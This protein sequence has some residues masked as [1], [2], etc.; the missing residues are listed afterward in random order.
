MKIL[1]SKWKTNI[2]NK[3]LLAISQTGMLKGIIALGLVFLSSS[4]AI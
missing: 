1:Q 2:K 4:S 3:E